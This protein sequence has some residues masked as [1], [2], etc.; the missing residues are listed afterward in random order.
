MWSIG[1][2]VIARLRAARHT[3]ATLRCANLQPAATIKVTAV[4]G[5][6]VTAKITDELISI[7][8]DG[9]KVDQLKAGVVVRLAWSSP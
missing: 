1:P 2:R 6:K 9:A 3:P 7:T 4:D 5:G 8:M